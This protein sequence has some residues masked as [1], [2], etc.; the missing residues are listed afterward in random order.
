MR[1]ADKDGLLSERSKCQSCGS[2]TQ[3][4]VR[5]HREKISIAHNLWFLGIEG[6]AGQARGPGC[7]GMP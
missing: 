7:P 1:A 5:A 2:V 6:K 3:L 4:N